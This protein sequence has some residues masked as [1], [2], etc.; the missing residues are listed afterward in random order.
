MTE[1]L[2]PTGTVNES[3]EGEQHV[4]CEEMKHTIVSSIALPEGANG[5]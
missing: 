1:A 4:D 3:G 2:F 5:W